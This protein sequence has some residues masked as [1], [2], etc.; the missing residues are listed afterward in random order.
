MNEATSMALIGAL[1]G[2]LLAGGLIWWQSQRRLKE[3]AQR[4]EHLEQARH[5]AVQHTSQAR[6]QIEQ[7]QKENGELRHL[8]ARS[9]QTVPPPRAMPVEPPAAEADDT[10]PAG[11]APTQLIQR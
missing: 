7:L 4:V 11:F 5:Q 8:L 10:P 3:A 2:A 9:G 1:V 6:R